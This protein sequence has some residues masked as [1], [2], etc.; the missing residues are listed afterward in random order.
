MSITIWGTAV[1]LYALFLGWYFNW[2][3]PL[4]AA[5]VDNIMATFEASGA[6]SNT[7]AEVMR[8]FLEADDGEEFVMQNLVKFN[9]GNISHP[10]S[11][12]LMPARDVLTDYFAP[13]TRALLWR[14][15]HPVIVSNKVGGYIDS[16]QTAP[17]PGWH[18]ASLMR[19]RSRKDLVELAL[20]PKFAGM[21]VYKLAAIQQTASFPTRT[22]MSFAAT[23]KFLVPL[24]LLLLAALAQNLVFVLRA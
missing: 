21:H 12:E 1:V 18:V 22:V 2:S 6:E 7:G 16:W 13:F 19:Y 24:L 3:G 15:G 9:A 4:T 14:G 10:T 17:D 23:P 5:E 20:D 11:G 8:R